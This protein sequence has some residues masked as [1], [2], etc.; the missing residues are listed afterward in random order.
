MNR[1]VLDLQAVSKIYELGE[2]HLYALDRID[3]KVLE[4]EFVAVVGPSGSGKS[5]FMHVASVLDKPSEGVVKIIDKQVN[6]Y[7]E[8]EAAKLRNREIGFV[9]QQ[10]NLLPKTSAEENVGLP[11]LYSGVSLKERKR[12]ARAILEQV[13]LG[14]RLR[15]T[16]AQLSGGQQQRVAIARAL[17]TDPRIIFADEPT[18]NLDSKAGEEIK[19]MLISLNN[20]GKTVVL[21][22]HDK[23][24]AQI[25]KRIILMNDGRIVSD[26]LTKWGKK[27]TATYKE[28]EKWQTNL[29]KQ[30]G[31][32][33][34]WSDP[35]EDS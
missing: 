22:T 1:V 5:T 32:K 2:Q 4:G 31:S 28:F 11:L 30:T 14:D 17:V 21:V 8:P 26:S 25:A 9:F 20:D 15:N 24:L 6:D 18:G 7:S 29:S 13:G 16:P 33:V 23:E 3:L 34:K 19:K 35:R 27:D 12:R 10:F